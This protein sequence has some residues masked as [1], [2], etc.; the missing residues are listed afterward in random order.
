MAKNIEFTY[1]DGSTE[2][3]ENISDFYCTGNKYIITVKGQNSTYTVNYSD[4][5]SYRETN[6]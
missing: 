4:V 6:E 3:F 5:K 1:T 2:T